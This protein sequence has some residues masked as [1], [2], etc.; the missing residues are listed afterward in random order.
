MAKKT[1]SLLCNHVNTHC[2][3]DHLLE[4]QLAASLVWLSVVLLSG[5]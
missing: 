4:G 1:F 2:G 3:I 5:V